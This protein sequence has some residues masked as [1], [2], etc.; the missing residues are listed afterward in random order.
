VTPADDG[1]G[2]RRERT[3][4][5]CPSALCR[6]NALLLG[7][8]GPDGVLA[9]VQPPTRIG[10]EFVSAARELGRPERRFRFSDACVEGACPQ[11]TGSGCGVIDIAIGPAPDKPAAEDSARAEKGLPACAIRRSCRWY[12]QRGAAACQ[13]CPAIVADT[14]GTDTY[15]SL[16]NGSP[17][18]VQP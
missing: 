12:A 13:V 5:A 15:H 14:G 7:V 2:Q 18:P 8:V 11:W 6:E 4:K 3:A 16:M 17:G 10:A 1:A 9:Y